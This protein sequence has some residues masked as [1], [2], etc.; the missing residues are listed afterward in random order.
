M[1][2]ILKF[3]TRH[4][5]TVAI[6]PGPKHRLRV[7]VLDAV[8][9]RRTRWMVQFEVQE[10]AGFAALKGFTDKAVAAGCRHS[11][12]VASTSAVRR[13]VA[14][15]ADLVTAGKIAVWIDGVRA[16]PRPARSA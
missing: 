11:F 9:P 16:R 4:I 2:K 5:Q 12:E 14:R 10:V 3:P 1:A 7:E 8:R 15:T 6:R 13:F